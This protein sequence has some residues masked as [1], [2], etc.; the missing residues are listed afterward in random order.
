MGTPRPIPDHIKAR[1]EEVKAKPAPDLL[2][3]A[4]RIRA[5]ACALEKLTKAQREFAEA[6]LR[7]EDALEGGKS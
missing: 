6:A 4:R 7:R 2:A 5:K 3:G 1:I